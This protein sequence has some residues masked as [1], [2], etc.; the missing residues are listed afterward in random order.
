MNKN[1]SFPIHIFI[2]LY[3]RYVIFCQEKNV[4]GIY[5]TDLPGFRFFMLQYLFFTKSFHKDIK[6][7]Q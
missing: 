6:F 1:R 4:P 3:H 5:Y 2:Q 7:R